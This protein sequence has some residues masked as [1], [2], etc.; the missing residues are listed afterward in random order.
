M[1]CFYQNMKAWRLH[2]GLTQGQ[3]AERSGISRPNLVAIENGRRE[4]TISTLQ[5]LAFALEVT[6]GMLLDQAPPVA[7]QRELDRH[8]IDQIA[9]SVISGK[10]DLPDSL[11]EIRDA[12]AHQARPLLLAAGIKRQRRVRSRNIVRDKMG[13]EQVLRR[14]SKLL[15]HYIIEGGA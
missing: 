9:R 3:V 10:R 7:A 6:P 1:P 8:E 5:R 4:C 14:L 15:P 12:A 2:R 13:M 11:L